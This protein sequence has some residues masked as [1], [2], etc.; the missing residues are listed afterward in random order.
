MY[1]GSQ[2]FEQGCHGGRVRYLYRGLAAIRSYAWVGAT[3][4]E[5]ADNFYVVVFNSIVN[6]SE[7]KKYECLISNIFRL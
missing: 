7:E 2:T 6:W 5:K 4:Q 3:R 1:T